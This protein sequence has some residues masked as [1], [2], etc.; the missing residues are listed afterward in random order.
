MESRTDLLGALRAGWWMVPVVF[1]AALAGAWLFGGEDRAPLYRS[2]ATLAVVPDTSLGDP[3]DVLN[4]VEVL[5][6]RTM[7]ATLSRLAASDVVRA[8]AVDRLDRP[9]EELDAYHVQSTVLPNTYLIDVTVR[10]PEPE[11]AARLAQTVAE[12]AVA[13]AGDYY[14]V[15]AL[16]VL[17]RA[18]TPR[19]PVARGEQRSYVVAGLLGLFVGVLA[20]FGVGLVRRT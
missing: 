4:T 10:G 19:G 1:V 5:D 16:R 7:V 9:A 2:S 18:A 17:D 13:E 3:S 8:R 15:F 12:A 20:A 14:R 11:T 6:R